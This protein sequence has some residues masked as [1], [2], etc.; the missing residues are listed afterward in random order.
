MKM[1][2]ELLIVDRDAFRRLQNEAFDAG[3]PLRICNAPVGEIARLQYM[4]K[5]AREPMFGTQIGTKG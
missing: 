2:P 1:R 4:H 5:R 3:V